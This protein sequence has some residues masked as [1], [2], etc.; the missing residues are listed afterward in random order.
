MR[1]WTF[2]YEIQFQTT[3][4][5]S[6]FEDSHLSNIIMY[7][8]GQVESVWGLTLPKIRIASKKVW[9]ISCSAL[10]FVQ[11]SPRAHMPIYPQSG[12][13]GSKASYLWNMVTYKNRKVDSPLN[14]AK[15]KIGGGVIFHRRTPL[16]SACFKLGAWL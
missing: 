7:K 14:A 8:N 2:L 5:W 11:K 1:S 10:N 13:R 16:I 6:F 15:V 4:I 9:N 12:G 3:F